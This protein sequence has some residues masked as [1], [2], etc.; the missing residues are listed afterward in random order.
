MPTETT[1]RLFINAPLSG[2]AEI[3]LNKMQSRHLARVMRLDAGDSVLLFN[4][5]HGEWRA[6]LKTAHK[7]A[8]ILACVSQTRSQAGSPDIWLLFAPV[9]KTGT[10][11]I[12]GKA[13]ELG[14]AELR[15]VLTE[16]TQSQR[17]NTDRLAL[18]TREAAE[19]CGR[20]DVPVVRDAR[21]LTDL[22]SDWPGGR[23]LFVL[24]ERANAP[25]LA[26]SLAGASEPA[27]LLIGPE[28][29][30]SVSELDALGKLPFVT[31]VSAGPRIMR[32]ETAAVAG[33]SVW[34]ALVGDW[35][36]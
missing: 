8:C 22:V 11:F 31:L 12:I 9:K 2:N 14:V 28:G 36:R 7:A 10:D 26:G 18:L 25:G 21:R 32:A 29:G 16:R 6:T 34:Q 33:L 27:A 3:T 4:G 20:M 5:R 19:Q 17:V 35:K 15:P 24:A 30:F 13:T 23:R 1:I